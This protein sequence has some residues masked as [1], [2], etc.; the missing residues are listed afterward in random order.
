MA[1]KLLAMAGFLV[2]ALS[3][4]FIDFQQSPERRWQIYWYYGIGLLLVWG[5]LDGLGR[6]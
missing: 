4:S 5:G 6:D 2:L 3:P 1:S